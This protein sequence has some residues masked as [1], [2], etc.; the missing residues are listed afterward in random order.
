MKTVLIG[1][2]VTVC[3]SSTNHGPS[4]QHIPASQFVEVEK[5]ISIDRDFVE[6]IS[7]KIKE[8]TQKKFDESGPVSSMITVSIMSVS[9]M[10]AKC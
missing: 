2:W 4:V 8:E 1:Y 9:V 5:H 10:E 3:L 7:G 6:K